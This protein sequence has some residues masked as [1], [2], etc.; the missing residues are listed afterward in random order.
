MSTCG[1]KLASSSSAKQKLVGAHPPCTRQFCS[2]VHTLYHGPKIH[3]DQ[4][5]YVFTCCIWFQEFLFSFLFFCVCVWRLP[6]GWLRCLIR[7][8]RI[9]FIRNGHYIAK[10][11]VPS[12]HSS[13]PW[14]MNIKTQCLQVATSYSQNGSNGNGLESTCIAVIRSVET[15]PGKKSRALPFFSSVIRLIMSLTDTR[16][17]LFGLQLSA[18][19]NQ[20]LTWG[21]E[22]HF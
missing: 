9:Y 5:S 15:S 19:N 16:P 8:F 1:D 4:Q 18:S 13:T 11:I 12:H 14:K 2:P 21:W 7:S 10:C 20:S 22:I 3:T 6:M 17:F